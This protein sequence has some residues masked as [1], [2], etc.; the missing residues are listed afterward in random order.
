MSSANHVLTRNP[1]RNKISRKE[2]EDLLIDK[3]P[4]FMNKQQRY[5]K[6]S[7]IIKEM[8]KKDKVIYNDSQST[9]FS[10]W[11]LVKKD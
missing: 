8:S 1:R 2:I 7:N 3:L 10:N 9:K 11:K 4:E 5:D 6:I